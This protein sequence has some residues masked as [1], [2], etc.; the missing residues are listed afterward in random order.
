M[1]RLITCS[2]LASGLLLARHHNPKLSGNDIIA[3]ETSSPRV[4]VAHKTESTRAGDD[5]LIV[6][7]SRG[8]RV[9]VTHNTM[10]AFVP[11][12]K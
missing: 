10:A 11:V 9:Q 7:G 8:E 3:F 1:K 5:L 4:H 12:G 2:L 6:T